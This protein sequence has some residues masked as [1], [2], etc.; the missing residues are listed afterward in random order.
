M[1]ANIEKL[2]SSQQIKVMDE[3]STRRREKHL[4]KPK[5]TV[6]FVDIAIIK[7]R[8]TIVLVVIY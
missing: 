6:T 1:A 7:N 3:S 2:C 5:A 4:E 8:L